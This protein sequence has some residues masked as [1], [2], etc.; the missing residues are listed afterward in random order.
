MDFAM[1]VSKAFV[2]AYA[3]ARVIRGDDLRL[4]EAAASLGAKRMLIVF[5]GNDV[6]DG[7]SAE[8]IAAGVRYLFDRFP[9]S[10]GVYGASAS[11]WG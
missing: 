6:T 9:C 7:A 1:Q 11:V 10:S 2:I 4:T 3:G 5:M 8:T